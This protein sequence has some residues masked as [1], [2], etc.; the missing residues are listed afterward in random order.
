MIYV[1]VLWMCQ[2]QIR[3]GTVCGEILDN[4]HDNAY[5]YQ[6]NQ[7]W[8]VVFATKFRYVWQCKKN[9]ACLDLDLKWINERYA[10]CV[11]A[12]T[13]CTGL[14]TGQGQ[15]PGWTQWKTMVTYPC[16]CAV[17][18]VHSVS[19]IYRNTSFPV[20]CPVPGPVQC[21]QAIRRKLVENMRR[22]I[23]G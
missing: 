9:K 4:Y 18:T 2:C 12:H 19:V 3:V 22:I 6:G 16:P 17:Y 5:R 20:P 1:I 23:V 11:M 10:V 21:K 7:Q 15:G 13:H 14:G 8:S